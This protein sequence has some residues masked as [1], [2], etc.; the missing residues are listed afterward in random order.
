[1]AII[2]VL[3]IIQTESLLNLISVTNTNA[4]INYLIQAYYNRRQDINKNTQVMNKNLFMFK[5]HSGSYSCNK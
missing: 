3:K 4:T 5:L 2:S 1:M